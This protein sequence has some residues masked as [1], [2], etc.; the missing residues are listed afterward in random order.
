MTTLIERIKLK[1]GEERNAQGNHVLYKDHLGKLTIGWGTLI[2]DGITDA[3][4]ELLL[5]ID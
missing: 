3:E 2:E 4:A 5:N 1:E